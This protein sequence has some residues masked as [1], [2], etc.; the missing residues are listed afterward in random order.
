[1]RKAECAIRFV[2]NS[3]SQSTSVSCSAE[4]VFETPAR[5]CCYDGVRLSWQPTPVHVHAWVQSQQCCHCPIPNPI[6]SM[7]LD[8]VMK[9]WLACVDCLPHHIWQNIDLMLAHAKSGALCFL[10]SLLDLRDFHL[11]RFVL[12]CLCF[13]LSF[14][15]SFFLC[16]F[17]W[18]NQLTPIVVSVVSEVNG[19]PAPLFQRQLRWFYALIVDLM[20]CSNRDLR[21]VVAGVFRSAKV[22]DLLLN[23]AAAA[24]AAEATPAASSEQ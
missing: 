4:F 10:R 24:A 7:Q 15:L 18:P 6:Q 1:M 9:H 16:L 2:S 3:V 21:L 8:S 17:L 20:G 13:F 5:F 11:F 14:F 22:A 12:F 19:M 23:A